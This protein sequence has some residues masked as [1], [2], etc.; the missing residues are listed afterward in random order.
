MTLQNLHTHT[1]YCDGRSTM[2]EMVNTAIEHGFSSLGFSPHSYMPFDPDTGMTPHEDKLYRAEAAQLKQ[3]YK[4]I[5][6]IYMGLEY[7]RHCVHQIEGYDYVIGSCHFLR[8]DDEIVLIDTSPQNTKNVIDTYFGGDSNAL[9]K[10][11]FE[12]MCELGSVYPFDIIGHFDVITKNQDQLHLFDTESADYRKY[13]LE[14]V[15]ALAEKCSIFEVNTGV[16]PR[17]GRGYP[18]PERF[19]LQEIKKVGA[20]VTIGSDCHRHHQLA[21]GYTEAREIIKSCGF[22]E[23]MI[24]DG[25]SFCPESL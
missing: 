9:A 21:E 25:K 5:I 12:T 7:E 15:H 14:A 1:P 4:G 6:D 16:M 20:H 24:F 18:Y 2:E 23:I 10:K 11:Y 17:S 8:I 22:E 3:K 13:A 19:I